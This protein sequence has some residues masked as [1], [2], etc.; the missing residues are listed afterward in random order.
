MVFHNN[1][2]N[3]WRVSTDT[4]NTHDKSLG[5]S[6]TDVTEQG[7]LADKILT[8]SPFPSH[9][10]KGSDYR[11]TAIR[12]SL[13]PNPSPNGEGSNRRDAPIKRM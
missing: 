7:G 3:T 2:K 13:T 12:K 8:P 4:D 10:A 11:D 1:K 6:P 5:V 9:K